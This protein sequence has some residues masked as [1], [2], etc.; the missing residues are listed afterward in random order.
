MLERV[1]AQLSV[2]EFYAVL[3]GFHLKDHLAKDVEKVVKKFVYFKVKRVGPTHCSG[4]EAEN[5]F[6]EAYK[7]NFFTLKVGEEIGV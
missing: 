3:G 7:E 6:R 2:K 4:V 5:L 1:K